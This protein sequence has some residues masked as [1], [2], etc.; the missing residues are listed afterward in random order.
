MGSSSR[1]TKG[2]V[3]NSVASAMPA[4][5]GW[6]VCVCVGRAH[7]REHLAASW[8]AVQNGAAA[9]AGGKTSSTLDSSTSAHLLWQV[10]A[11]G[12]Q[13]QQQLMARDA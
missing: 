8:R 9:S 3:T 12:A 5:E 7:V 10:A 6:V 2:M 4:Q 11:A 13:Q 1:T